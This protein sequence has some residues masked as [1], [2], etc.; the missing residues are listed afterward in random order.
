MFFLKR[1]SKN[2][3]GTISGESADLAGWRHEEGRAVV[4]DGGPGCVDKGE[5]VGHGVLGEAVL[6]GEVAGGLVDH[7]AEVAD[8]GRVEVASDGGQ[9]HGALGLGKKQ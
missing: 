1:A 8:G 9:A 6:L 4:L 2:H 7:G 5:A 3:L